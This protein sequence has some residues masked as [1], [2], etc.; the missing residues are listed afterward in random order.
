MTNGP[1]WACA[2][3][4]ERVRRRSAAGIDL[5]QHLGH[6]AVFAALGEAGAE[7]VAAPAAKLQGLAEFFLEA[8]GPCGGEEGNVV[9]QAENVAFV[10]RRRG[11]GIDLRRRRFGRLLFCRGFPC[12]TAGREGEEHC[13]AEEKRE[14]LFHGQRRLSV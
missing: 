10:Q 12:G 11:L 7:T 9:L 1:S 5:L 8:V 3:I 4:G 14:D 6:F 2:I 13:R